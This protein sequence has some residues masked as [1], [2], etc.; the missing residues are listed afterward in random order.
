MS[1]GNLMSD[2]LFLLVVVA[3]T[4]ILYQPLNKRPSKHYWEFKIDSKIPLIPIFIIP[5]LYFFFPYIFLSF[6]FL[7]QSSVILDFLKCFLLANI[8]ACLVWYFFP[9]GV[10]R[11]QLEATGILRKM[12][13][14]LYKIDKYD[15]NG[16]PSGHV[17]HSL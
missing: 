2:K 8:I 14:G 15:T 1:L 6:V 17:Y 3:L 13:S 9:N 5:Y 7:W 16:F 10:K 11:P 12:I 4:A